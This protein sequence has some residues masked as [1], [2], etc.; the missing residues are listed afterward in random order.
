MVYSGAFNNDVS[1]DVEVVKTAEGLI[2]RNRTKGSEFT[3]SSAKLEYLEETNVFAVKDKYGST[4]LATYLEW[5][6]RGWLRKTS[7]GITSGHPLIIRDSRPP[8]VGR[9]PDNTQ[10]AGRPNIAQ[11]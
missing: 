9:R 2:I 7:G 3:L 8:F 6:R 5:G 4:C 11:S 1:Y 10:L